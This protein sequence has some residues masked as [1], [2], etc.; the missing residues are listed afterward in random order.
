MIIIIGA[1]IT[2]LSAA[3]ELAHRHVPF[4]LVEAGPRAGGLIHTE[5]IDGFTIDAGADSILVQKPAALRLCEELGLSGRLMPTRTPRTAFVAR[6]RAPVST[7]LAVGARHPDDDPGAGEVLA[8]RLARA[9]PRG[10]R[11]VDSRAPRRR[12]IGRVLLPPALR[13]RDRR[14]DRRAAARRHPCRRRRAVV[15]AVA[16]SAIHGGR[17]PARRRSSRHLVS[18]GA[19]RSVSRASR[20]DVGTGRR[21]RAQDA[22]WR[23]AAQHPG[24]GDRT[25]ASRL[26]GHRRRRRPRRGQRDRGR[27]A[28]TWPR[29]CCGPWT[30]ARRASVR[31]C[32]TCRP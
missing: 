13:R 5:R 25:D 19:G 8:A 7:A 18:G 4:V 12:R 15:D 26:D 11:T 28:R 20:R 17:A 21:D 3:Y 2:G 22:A 32:P 16:L 6:D 24:L 31:P 9:R 27:A 10:G 30:T 23:D 29:H 1:G 14:P